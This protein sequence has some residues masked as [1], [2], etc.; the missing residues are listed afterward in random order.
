MG[1]ILDKENLLFLFSPQF[2]VHAQNLQKTERSKTPV[3][4]IVEIEIGFKKRWAC[5]NQ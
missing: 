2:T 4:L 1:R 3:S 5:T